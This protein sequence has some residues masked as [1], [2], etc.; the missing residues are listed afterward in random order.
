MTWCARLIAL[1]CASVIGSAVFAQDR[2]TPD[3]F[4]DRADGRTF[5]FERFPVGGLVGVEQF[6]SRTRTVWATPTGT[7]TY[8]KIE[9]RGP[10][11]CFIYEDLSN[12]E[13]CW[14]PFSSDDGLLV[15]SITGGMQRISQ[16]SRKPVICEDEAIS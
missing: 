5:T 7:C 4:L 1:A 8:G 6:L 2:L 12:P 16:I 14:T 9:V 3:E 15:M 10:L 11:I 13:H